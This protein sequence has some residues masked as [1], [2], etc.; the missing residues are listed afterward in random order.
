MSQGRAPSMRTPDPASRDSD[1]GLKSRLVMSGPAAFYAD[2]GVEWQRPAVPGPG[3][4]MKKKPA[5]LFLLAALAAI[6]PLTPLARA[7]DLSD[8]DTQAVRALVLTDAEFAKYVQATRRLEGLRLA[9]WGDDERG[10]GSN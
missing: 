6:A 7:A 5:P 1:S 3:Q 10:D 4:P 9:D 2:A 8:P